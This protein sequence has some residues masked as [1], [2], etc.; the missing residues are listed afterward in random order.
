MA[1]SASA[2]LAH[3]PCAS[4]ADDAAE[5]AERAAE[6]VYARVF[7]RREVALLFQSSCLLSRG[8]EEEGRAAVE[9]RGGGKRGGVDFGHLEDGD[10]EADDDEAHDEGY[11]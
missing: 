8:L 7:I 3:T 9:L 11:D 5:S 6:G 2:A 4:C 1:P 10:A